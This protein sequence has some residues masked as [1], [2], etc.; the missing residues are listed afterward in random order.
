[1]SAL[2][3]FFNNK[4][5]ILK[6][7]PIFHGL[8][9][10]ELN[11]VSRHVEIVDFNK[12]DIICLQGAPADA[13]YALVSGRVYS[14]VSGQAGEKQDVDFILRG[15]SFGIISALTGENHSHTYEAI[16]DSVVIR[17]NKD[18]FS[19]LL[20]S[21]PKLAV[22]LSQSLS[23]R[24]RSQVTHTR[25]AQECTII[26]VYAPVAGSGASTYAAN[27]ALNLKEQ[28]GKKILLLSLS[29]DKDEERRD[30]S[31]IIEDDHLILGAI[32]RG[33]LPVDLLSVR[34][35]AQNPMPAGKIS[36]FVAA[37]VNDYHYIV[38]DLP[39]EM[40]DVVMKTLT[41]SD[42]IHLV[43]LDNEKNLEA[44]RHVIDKLAGRLKERFRA[45]R[46]QVII[47]GVNTENRLVPQEIKKILNYDVFLV[48]PHLQSAE[49]AY[50]KVAPG[51]AF[52]EVDAKSE[53]AKTIRRLSRQISRVMVGLVLGGGAALG[54]AHIGVIRVL[55][56]EGIPVDVVVGSSMGA[57]IASLWAVGNNAASLEEF[58]REF[59]NKSALLHVCDPIFP[60]AGLIGGEGIVHWL[61]GKL[62]GKTF[63]DGKIP[64]RVVTYDLFHR[65]EVVVSDGLLVDA[66]RKSVAIPGVIT[67]VMEGR[68]MIIDGG[69]LNP[70]P[71]NVLADMGVK[72]IIAV[73][74]LQSPEEVDWSQKKADEDIAKSFDVSFSR[75]PFKFL[76][77]RM[78]WL[79]SRMLTPNIADIV[80]RTLQAS[81]YVIAET[82]AKQADV[83]IHP[84][85]R[86]INWFELYKVNE[87][88][89]R[90]EEAAQKA[91]PAIKALVN[92]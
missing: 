69:V 3:S 42:V 12:G 20:Q 43:S 27:L 30:L 17:I 78:G 38:L 50:K 5:P 83:L 52:V 54:M 7:I 75:H 74:V 41:Q 10:F 32:T 4:L 70:L 23:L 61:K 67:P 55:E 22:A 71:T 25:S 1:M 90:G 57:L 85:L 36:R 40:D 28:T 13:F 66:V 18:N 87:L 21:I 68:Q 34:F 64:L 16:N 6:Q 56:R 63:H 11:R 76:G 33:V 88:I 60:V 51:F 39:N 82:S 89:Q 59:E 44:T 58:G 31:E 62:G 2:P 77:F 37:P 19:K 48:L 91:L 45:D 9:W 86:G 15:M 79:L 65:K 53:Y 29:S 73:N 84:D 8:N 14:Y 92:K 47:G 26:A 49:F 72:K 35:D 24:M 46:V 80:V 81:E